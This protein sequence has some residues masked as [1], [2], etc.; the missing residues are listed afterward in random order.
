MRAN[1]PCVVSKYFMFQKY[2]EY[3]MMKKICVLMALCILFSAIGY[4]RRLSSVLAYDEL[5]IDYYNCGD[6]TVFHSDYISDKN[7]HYYN[8]A[9]TNNGRKYGCNDLVFNRCGEENRY[10]PN[11]T[12]SSIYMLDNSQYDVHLDING[13]PV[14][15]YYLVRANAKSDMVGADVRLCYI[16]YIGDKNY[17]TDL[18]KI[19]P[20]GRIVAR[21]GV[22]V[23]GVTAGQWFSYAVAIDMANH[24]A[25]IYISGTYKHTVSFSASI[26]QLSLV[27]LWLY[28]DAENDGDLYL[29][30][31]EVTGMHKKYTGDDSNMSSIFHSV[32]PIKE[33]LADKTAFH[34][35]SGAMFTGGTKSYPGIEYNEEK[36]EI[37]GD[38][39]VINKTFGINLVEYTSFFKGSGITIYKDK[40]IAEF[41]DTKT[42]LVLQKNGSKYLIPVKEFARELMDRYVFDDSNGMIIVSKDEINLDLAGEIPEYTKPHNTV[43]QYTDIIALNRF[44][45]FERPS[46]D[47]IKAD[48][49][50]KSAPHPR[51]MADKAQ[52]DLLRDEYYRSGSPAKSMCDTIVLNADRILKLDPREYNIPDKQRILTISR[53]L[54]R[55]MEYLG[56]AYQI[57]GNQVYADCAWENLYKTINFPDWNPSHMI[58]VGELNAAFAIGFDWMYDGFTEEQRQQIYEGVKRQGLDVTRLCYYGRVPRWAQWANYTSAFTSWKSNFN[59]VINGG[60]LAAAMAFA[61]YDPDYCFDIA[62]KAVRSLEYTMIG[63]QPDG[64]WIESIAY[65]NYTLSYLAKGVGSMLTTIGTDYGLMD[66]PGVEKT[67]LWIRSMISPQGGNNFHD[68]SKIKSAPEWCL[69]LGN[70]YNNTGY[71]SMRRSATTGG[72]GGVY[73]AIWYKSG[74]PTTETG[75][76]L[77]VASHGI[78]SVSDRSAYGDAN[79]MYFSAHGG[80]VFCYHSHCDTGNF[81]YEANGVRWVDDLGSENY[82]VQ[83]DGGLGHYGSYRRRAEAHSVVVINPNTGDRDGGQRDDAFSP[84]LKAAETGNGSFSEYNMTDAYRDYVSFYHRQFHTDRSAKSLVISD[85]INLKDTGDVCWFMITPATVTWTDNTHFVLK[86]NNQTLYGAV[87]VVGNVTDLTGTTTA[88]EPLLGAPVLEGQNTNSGYSR[89]VVRGNGEGNVLIRVTLSPDSCFSS[90]DIAGINN[91]IAEDASVYNN[92]EPL[93][94]YIEAGQL[95]ADIKLHTYGTEQLDSSLILAHYDDMGNLLKV[96]YSDTLSVSLDT[97]TFGGYIKTY[98]WDMKNLRP[99]K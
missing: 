56:A 43:Y 95:S 5:D 54:L 87:D 55:R 37:Y 4:N 19:T 38:C 14:Y 11:R 3:F 26:K 22:D 74:V 96:K 36:S 25:D 68:S 65:W 39:K 51:I 42:T 69:W 53:E 16:R 6:Y 92:G 41:G 62:E 44:L 34:G 1:C 61:E 63:F 17:D 64:S 70:V 94:D 48:F 78:E 13:I 66:Y 90:D 30:E 21:D 27:R 40:G 57:T 99:I 80:S 31:L 9:Y 15:S 47:R 86:K 50:A 67:A 81:V 93:G 75:L 58:D 83:R 72:G 23:G 12:D 73:D 8:C 60:A 91:Y 89:I 76:P 2:G 32:E 33:Y 45:A 88:C 18:L 77:Y 28:H 98:L 84:L 29:D 46:A 79:A 82:D 7:N 24:N 59:A 71:S 97:E 52:F 35:Y 10:N 20:S 85:Y 49:E